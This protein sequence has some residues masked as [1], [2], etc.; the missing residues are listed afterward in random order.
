MLQIMRV[1]DEGGEV[2]EYTC[3]MP[4]YYAVPLILMN[5]RLAWFEASCHPDGTPILPPPRTTTATDKDTDGATTTTT[6]ANGGGRGGGAS[7]ERDLREYAYLWQVRTRFLQAVFDMNHERRLDERWRHDG[8][9]GFVHRLYRRY[10]HETNQRILYWRGEIK[11]GRV[12][13]ATPDMADMGTCVCF[14]FFQCRSIAGPFH[15]SPHT[16][17][18]LLPLFFSVYSSI[19]HARP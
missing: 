2:E 19:L 5:K 10:G 7:S 9:H 11:A 16:V 6:T 13:Y 12:P 8:F 17:F 14:L 15:A 3:A 1:E 18:F 4:R